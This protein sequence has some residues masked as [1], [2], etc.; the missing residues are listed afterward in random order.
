MGQTHSAPSSTVLASPPLSRRPKKDA[1]FRHYADTPAKPTV[2]R[3]ASTPRRRLLLRRKS[4]QRILQQ[5]E[6]AARDQQVV[7]RSLAD[8]MPTTLVLRDN[9][10][11][12]DK[13]GELEGLMIRVGGRE[14][15]RSDPV[16][17]LHD[18]LDALHE[19]FDLAAV[20]S[21]TSSSS[22]RQLS[23]GG[24]HHPG[25]TPSIPLCA[26]FTVKSE[27]ATE[28]LLS[29]SVLSSHSP[30]MSP[31]TPASHWSDSSASDLTPLLPFQSFRDSLNLSLTFHRYSAHFT[32]SSSVG[33]DSSAKSVVPFHAAPGRSHGGL[34]SLL[35]IHAEGMKAKKA[36]ARKKGSIVVIG[37]ERIG[38]GRYSTIRAAEQAAAAHSST[39]GAKSTS[40]QR[41]DHGVEGSG[42]AKQAQEDEGESA[43]SE[44]TVT[45]GRK[46]SVTSG[47]TLLDVCD[48]HV[49]FPPFRSSSEATAPENAISSRLA[50]AFPP[51][52]SVTCQ[53]RNVPNCTSWIQFDSPKA[54]SLRRPSPPDL[55]LTSYV[56]ASPE[57]ARIA[58]N[59]E[60]CRRAATT[61]SPPP[62]TP[63]PAR[64]AI[65]FPVGHPANHHTRFASASPASHALATPSARRAASAPPAC[66]HSRQQPVA[67]RRRSSIHSST[68]SRTSIH[69]NKLAAPSPKSARRRVSTPSASG[70]LPDAVAA[71]PPRLNTAFCF[72]PPA[73]LDLAASTR[74]TDGVKLASST[75][76][77][78]A[79]T[80]STASFF[81]SR[82]SNSSIEI[83]LTSPLSVPDVDFTSATRNYKLANEIDGSQA[84][85]SGN[86]S[87]VTFMLDEL[88]AGNHDKP[89]SADIAS[90]PVDRD[91]AAPS[92][93]PRPI[94]RRSLEQPDL[95]V[96]YLSH[97][98]P[99]ALPRSPVAFDDFSLAPSRSSAPRKLAFTVSPTCRHPRTSGL[100]DSPPPLILNPRD[101]LAPRAPVDPAM[102]LPHPSPFPRDGD[103]DGD[104]GSPRVSPVL[105]LPSPATC[106]ADPLT[107][108]S[109][110]DL[111]RRRAGRRDATRAFDGGTFPASAPPPQPRPT[112]NDEGGV[113]G[114]VA[115]VQ[116]TTVN[117]REGRL[118]RVEKRGFSNGEIRDWMVQA[119]REARERESLF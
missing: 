112:S 41:S 115:E 67:C 86:N 68:P 40:R 37:A 75:Y 4:R 17:D 1:L 22:S 87:V 107:R 18:A 66:G 48:S 42:S 27:N 15:S 46:M 11:G 106:A 92:L 43:M 52:P 113:F 13:D 72:N 14:L 69:S 29:L 65:R 102:T 51:S 10:H 50:P 108:A 45:V 6:Q 39:S 71:R 116:E 110:R 7:A 74:R 3:D 101:H 53:E 78:D 97:P 49:P 55:Q 81:S 80:P 96:L 91:D 33:N 61:P 5:L 62:S 111:L 23:L 35:K 56:A 24:H 100:F 9:M 57:L 79:A 114:A 76:S 34:G 104:G 36:R 58:P 95:P 26:P 83:P 99:P 8:S 20:T 47:A 60:V 12:P 84:L 31:T 54:A 30:A 32:P 93:P 94:G 119:R 117:V 88:F 118:G 63:S 103:G 28:T 89:R 21:A 19:R 70:V 25:S 85:S 105:P 38:S 77:S 44:P 2:W 16:P 109:T 98:S 73:P 90:L 82:T 64:V 59:D